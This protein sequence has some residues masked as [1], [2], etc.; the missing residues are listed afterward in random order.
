MF[1]IGFADNYA[2]QVR[3]TLVHLA[4]WVLLITVGALA[5]SK[6]FFIPGLL[7]GWSGS[8]IYFL[9]M[10]RRVKKSAE[11]PLGQ[12]VSTM[13]SGWLIRLSFIISLLVVSVYVPEIDFLAAVVGL[14]SLH[15]ILML[16]AVFFVVSELIAGVGKSKLTRER[17]EK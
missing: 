10:C 16:N 5:S 15:I 17:S 1:K 12:A 7:L 14:F 9:L 13:R 3:Q 2:V 11:L 6:M 8:V 4:V